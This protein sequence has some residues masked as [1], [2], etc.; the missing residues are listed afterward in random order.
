MILYDG[1]PLAGVPPHRI[2]EM[3]IAPRAGGPRDFFQ[4]HRRGKSGDRRHGRTAAKK[5]F[6]ADRDRALDLFPR[7]RERLKQNAGTLSGGEQ[8]MLAI[9]RALPAKPRLL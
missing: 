7:L 2:V 9:A 6:T 8:Q 3:G 5:T 1:Q 4:L